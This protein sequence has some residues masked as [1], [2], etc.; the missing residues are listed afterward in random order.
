MYVSNVIVFFA[1]RIASSIAGKISSPFRSVVT[2]FPPRIAGPRR[3]PMERRN[4]GSST[5]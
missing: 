1:E 2:L 5:A 4:W 3:D